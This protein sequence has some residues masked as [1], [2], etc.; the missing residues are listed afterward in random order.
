MSTTIDQNDQ[1]QTTA[2]QNSLAAVIA[3]PKWAR[4]HRVI[5]AL[6]EYKQR[7]DARSSLQDR[8]DALCTK[9]YSGR[10]SR[11][12]GMP[13]NHDQFAAS[14]HFAEMLDEKMELERA[15]A[16]E[17]EDEMGAALKG[18]DKR[19]QAVIDEFYLGDQ[20]R[21]ATELLCALYGLSSTWIYKIRDTALDTLYD[22]LGYALPEIK[23]AY[24]AQA[25]TMEGEFSH[26]NN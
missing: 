26:D 25:I 12:T 6:K 11:I 4:R 19:E 2:T 16:A 1:R 14:D 17:E 7:L 8:Y 5:E 15:L 24:T 18:L 10:S 9:L 3:D 22:L 21:K 20:S 23:S 13:V